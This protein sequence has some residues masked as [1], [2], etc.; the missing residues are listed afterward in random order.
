MSRCNSCVH[1]TRENPPQ[2]IVDAPASK[3]LVQGLPVLSCGAWKTS[4]GRQSL[5][6]APA[7]LRR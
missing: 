4:E 2:C 1:K 6:E 3:R 5:T 7:N